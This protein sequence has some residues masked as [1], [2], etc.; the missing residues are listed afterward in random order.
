M[1]CISRPSAQGDVRLLG[2]TRQSLCFMHLPPQ[3]R[4]PRALRSKID[5]LRCGLWPCGPAARFLSNLA[6]LRQAPACYVHG[7][8]LFGERQASRKPDRAPAAARTCPQAARISRDGGR[9][10]NKK[11]SSNQCG[12]SPSSMPVRSSKANL[13][14]RSALAAFNPTTRVWRPLRRIRSITFSSA[15]MAEMSQKCA[16]LTS[17]TT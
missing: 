8:K 11:P 4:I 7:S 12:A 9:A 15:P 10:E 13:S 1:S 16:R 14:N 2:F 5:A 17:I 3:V 6:R